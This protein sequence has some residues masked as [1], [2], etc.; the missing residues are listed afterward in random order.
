MNKFI[1]EI[2]KLAEQL[3]LPELKF[4]SRIKNSIN[5][6]LDEVDANLISSDNLDVL[7]NFYNHQK[8]R[9]DFCYIDPPYNTGQKFIYSDSFV[10]SST[11]LWGAHSAWLSFMLPRLYLVREILNEDGIL[12]VSIDDYEFHRLKVLLDK[13]FGEHNCLATIIVN[14]SKNGKGSMIGVAANHEYVLIYGKSSK[15]RLLG[16]PEGRTEEYDKVDEHGAYKIDGLFRKKGDASLRQD[17]PKMYFPLYYSVNGIVSTVRTVDC[18][19]EVFPVDSAG[20]ER[21]WLWGQSKTA[22]ESWKLYASKSGVVY[23]KNYLTPE[24]RVKIRSIWDDVGY[25]TERATKEIKEIY[26][27]KVFETPKPLKLIEH[28][29]Q[30]CAKSNAVVLD[31]FAGTGTTAH[32]IYNLNIT[33]GANRKVVLVEQNLASP[34]DH[35]ATKSG[36]HTL[37]EITATRLNHIKKLDKSYRFKV[38]T[39]G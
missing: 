20:I 36:F 29:I 5:I 23:V 10:G 17:R 6:D 30:C 7:L 21:R 15:S 4:E 16:L 3:L 25:L 19:K 39:F 26:G 22:E 35:I 32:A 11:N 24:K 2:N 34:K 37:S 27:E 31:F 8:P 13:I 33:E 28:L 9:F 14:R 1:T 38:H 12:A 18:D